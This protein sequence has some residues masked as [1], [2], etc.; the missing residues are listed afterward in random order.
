MGVVKCGSV[1]IQSV[2]RR[3]D[4]LNFSWC[5]GEVLLVSRSVLEMSGDPYPL[6]KEWGRQ[7]GGRVVHVQE[8]CV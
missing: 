7:Y 4:L 6:W 3:I 8:L 5:V 2:Y 1:W